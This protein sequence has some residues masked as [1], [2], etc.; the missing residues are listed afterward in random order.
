MEK[1]TQDE[2][3]AAEAVHVA[4]SAALQEQGREPMADP[5]R[6]LLHLGVSWLETHS[7]IAQH[8]AQAAK[9]EGRAQ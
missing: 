4:L 2:V 6:S 8:E 7:R 9:R 5:L 3:L 1:L